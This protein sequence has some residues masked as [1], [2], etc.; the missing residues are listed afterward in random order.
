MAAGILA[1]PLIFSYMSLSLQATA[2]NFIN[3]IT[4]KSSALRVLGSDF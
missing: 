1:T 4:S 2:K 3:T